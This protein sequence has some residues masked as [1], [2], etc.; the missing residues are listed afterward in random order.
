MGISF[1]APLALL[2][3][4]PAHRPDRRAVPQRAP[5]AS[6]PAGGASPWSSGR[7]S[8]RRSSSRSPGSGSCCRSTG[9]R[10]CSS[11]TCPTRSATRVARMRSRSC[12]RRSTSIP[13]GDV[14]GIVAFGKEA[15]VERLPVR[16][17]A[18]STG[19]P[20]RRSRSA[21]D[22]GAALRLATRPVP[23]RRPE[24]DR[25]AVGRQRHDRRRP[26]RGGA[27]RDARH[28]IETRTHRARRRRTRS[29]SSG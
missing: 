4:I 29:S 10:R 16:P 2:L 3:L 17:R 26:G 28:P 18:R 9:S 20:R 15:L 25:A 14:A 22:I 12:A 13:D 5:A 19:S 8:C 1:D 27:R 21:T 7:C 11:S 23:R 6:G 24:A